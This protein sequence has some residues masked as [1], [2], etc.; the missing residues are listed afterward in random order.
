M[1]EEKSRLSED[2]PSITAPQGSSDTR[3]R[4]IVAAFPDL[5]FRMS[6]AGIYLEV[7]ASDETMLLYP[8]THYPGKSV[9]DLLPSAVADQ[10]LAKFAAAL[11]TGTVQVVQHQIVLDGHVREREARIVAC[12]PDEVL[13]IVR[14]MTDLRRTERALDQ[15]SRRL[16]LAHTMLQSMLLGATLEEIVL[17]ALQ[18]FCYLLPSET[19]C[20]VLFD[21]DQQPALVLCTGQAVSPDCLRSQRVPGL[22]PSAAA[23]AG[24]RQV[25][26]DLA[27]L[28]ALDWIQQQMSQKGIH[29]YLSTPVQIEQGVIGELAFG[30]R[31]PAAF[32]AAQSLITLQMADQLAAAVAHIRL[33]EQVEQSNIELQKRVI[34][35]T[36]EV[37]RTRSRVEAILNNSSDGI[38]LARGDGSISQ[39]NSMFDRMLGYE[40]DELFHQPLTAFV[41][42]D[43]RPDF[44]ATLNAVV[45]Q[46][47]ISRLEIKARCKDGRLFDAEV[48]LSVIQVAE[49]D[50]RG[51]IVCQVRDITERKRAE[52]EL[53]VALQRERELSELKTRF[54]SMAS[55]EFRTPLTTILSSLEILEQYLERLTPDQKLRHF[56]QVRRS[57]T[58]MTELLDEVLLYGKAEAGQL[59]LNLLP[60]NLPPLIQEI[61]EQVRPNAGKALALKYTVDDPCSARLIDERLFRQM[62]TNL[63]T[64]AIKYSPTGGEVLLEVK[65]WAAETVIRVQDHGIGIPPEDQARLFEPFHRAANVGTIPGTG[66]GLS[67]S[68]RTVDLHGGTIVCHSTPGVG[69]TFEVRLPVIQQGGEEGEANQ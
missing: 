10:F 53:R 6:R 55:H 57:V 37:E 47:E 21:T 1:N 60:V 30:A 39:T 44:E 65:C 23:L 34:E 50:Q 68:K 58:H 24:Q 2:H 22:C 62:L 45:Q 15:Y 4:A 43:F 38:V 14:D 12:G 67:I 49:H 31:Y 59:V 48:G 25:V 17:E 5:L 52:A 40:T 9:T 28:P 32:N 64:N 13:M 51:G 66:L 42:P 26:D 69:T 54:V 18:G 56:N 63:L 35:R 8:R 27:A 3:Y 11:D 7:H 29:A 41:H 46:G 61:V 19:A 20:L 16:N 36:T 33:R